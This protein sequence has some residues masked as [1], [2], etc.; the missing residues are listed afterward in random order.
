M[1]EA[2]LPKKFMGIDTAS[3]ETSYDVSNYV[4]ATVIDNLEYVVYY[5]KDSQVP[6]KSEGKPEGSKPSG[7]W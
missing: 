2:K 1:V 6:G 7:S 5:K 3:F 4:G